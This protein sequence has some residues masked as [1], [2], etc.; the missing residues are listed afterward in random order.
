MTTGKKFS[1]IVGE[2]ADNNKGALGHQTAS[3]PRAGLKALT[4]SFAVMRFLKLHESH[5]S[6]FPDAQGT[7]PSLH[8]TQSPHYKTLTIHFTLPRRHLLNLCHP[9]QF[10]TQS[11]P[12]Q[13]SPRNG[14]DRTSSTTPGQE[15]P[16][17]RH[18]QRW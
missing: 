8:I 16:N 13:L 2:V 14:P 1:L 4:R 7:S 3:A 5:F 10:P 12:P 18:D 11:R 6:F 15:T 17:W 9:P